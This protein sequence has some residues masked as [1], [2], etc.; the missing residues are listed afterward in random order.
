VGTGRPEESGKAREIP[1]P[2]EVPGATGEGIEPGITRVFEGT[3][4]KAV[5]GPDGKK[6]LPVG[7]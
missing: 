7:F 3:S 5:V 2:V 1:L 4:G 6:R